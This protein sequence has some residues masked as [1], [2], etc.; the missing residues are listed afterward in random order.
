LQ[1]RFRE[2]LSQPKE[3][4][5]L[6]QEI[7]KF[8]DWFNGI[9]ILARLGQ[10]AL[11]LLL[12]AYAI[13][14]WRRLAPWIAPSSQL[15]RLCFRVALDR[16]AE[17]GLVR[18]FGETRE[19]FALR[20]ASLVPELE[21]FTTGHMRRAVGGLESFGRGGWLD[22]RSRIDARI[23]SVFSVGR[24]LLGLLNPVSWIFVR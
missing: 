7:N 12:L 18:R 5:P 14:I 6:Q 22:L 13:K 2:K 21:E 1:N 23:S 8:L 9:L 16:L 15:Y 19:E 24:R 3:P 20:M 11:F 17:V 10:L 4:D